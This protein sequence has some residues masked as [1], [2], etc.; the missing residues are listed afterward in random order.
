[1]GMSTYQELTDRALEYI[2]SGNWEDAYAM[3]KQ[4]EAE[5]DKSD[6]TP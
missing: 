1:M 3:L 5:N 6:V 4:K 2:N